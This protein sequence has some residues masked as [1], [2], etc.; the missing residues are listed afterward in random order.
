MIYARPEGLILGL[1][2]LQLQRLQYHRL[3]TTEEK[4]GAEC[5]NIIWKEAEH[6]MMD[7]GLSGV[8]LLTD[9]HIGRG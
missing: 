8:K 4:H 5:S 1:T 9:I 2:S 3:W 6:I 7:S